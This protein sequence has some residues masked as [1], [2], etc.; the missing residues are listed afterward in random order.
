ME[1]SLSREAVSRLSIPWFPNIFCNLSVHYHDHTGQPL[2]P[3]PR[4]FTTI[5]NN[6]LVHSRQPF[7]GGKYTYV[8]NI[9]INVQ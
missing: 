8:S 4:I 3:I 5:I 7:C 1:L 9:N 2:A 6:Q